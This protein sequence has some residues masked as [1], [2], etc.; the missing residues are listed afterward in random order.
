MPPP[1]ALGMMR[2]RIR[3]AAPLLYGLDVLKGRDAAPQLIADVRAL[4]QAPRVAED[5]QGHHL[6]QLL[7]AVTEVA[8]V[9]V[10][11]VLH[12]D[13]RFGL[14]LDPPS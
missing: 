6:L 4:T 8:G 10:K 9:A 12:Q 13:Q 2:A 14:L 3:L 7:G 1:P 5:L 11:P